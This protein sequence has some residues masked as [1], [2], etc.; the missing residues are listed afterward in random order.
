LAAGA[1]A[2]KSGLGLFRALVLLAA[3]APGTDT[4]MGVDL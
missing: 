3:L 4:V 1:V 2:G